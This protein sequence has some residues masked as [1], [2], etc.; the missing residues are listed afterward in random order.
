[1]EMNNPSLYQKI[2]G[3]TIQHLVCSAFFLLLFLSFLRVG[4]VIPRTCRKFDKVRQLVWKRVVN[5]LPSGVILKILSAKNIQDFSRVLE[6]PISA[7]PG[8]VFCAIS[9]L[10]KLLMIPTYPRGPNQPLFSVPDMK[11]GWIPLSQDKVK[12]ILSQKI[13]SL[14]LD[15]K[16]YK[17]HAFRR[18]G[19][20]AGSK[21]VANLELLR[22][23]GGWQSEAWKVYMDLPAESRFNVSESIIDFLSN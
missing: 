4:N 15:P 22:L 2:Y 19:M 14:G 23:H 11:G 1:M 5:K 13:K 8:S 16:R 20:Q 21:V 12:V 10:Q 9:A 7:K 17:F 3:P 18:G 6:V